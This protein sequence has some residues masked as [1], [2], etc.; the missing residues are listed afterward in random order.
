MSATEDKKREMEALVIEKIK[1]EARIIEIKTRMSEIHWGK[2]P[3][4]ID[5]E[6]EVFL[7]FYQ[8]SIGG[9]RVLAP[10][11]F[12]SSEIEH[13][14]HELYYSKIYETGQP[15][16]APSTMKNKATGIVSI[17]NGVA[18][19]GTIIHEFVQRG[20]INKFGPNRIKAERVVRKKY[21]VTLG[22]QITIIEISGH[23]DIDFPNGDEDR[24]ADIKTTTDMNFKKILG[25]LPCSEDEYAGLK[26]QS[27]TG[28]ANSYAVMSGQDGKEF[29]ILW[30]SQA[31]L[32]N[33]TEPFMAKL[34]NFNETLIKLAK[35]LDAVN[36][37]KGGDENFRPAFAGVASCSVCSHHNIHC[38]GKDAVL[39]GQKTL[40]QF[41]LPEE[42]A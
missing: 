23:V 28:Q 22:G 38:L 32:D 16:K 20:L 33:K 42:T 31:N 37:Y 30:I 7:L 12:R 35:V 19:V 41:K 3:M 40:T 27:A 17:P 18:T 26:V 5:L 24:L 9:G 25:L 2:G 6:R 11:E 1:L 36:K 13:C 29:D 10:N 34:T 39:G 14:S 21:K 4:K 8:T 15:P